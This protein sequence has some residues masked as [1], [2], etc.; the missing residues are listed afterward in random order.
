L[1]PD[2]DPLIHVQARLQLMTTLSALPRGDRITH[3]RLQELHGLSA[4]NL[5]THLRK[6]EEA[7]YVEVEKAFRGRRPVTWVS[8]TDKG[9]EA[10]AAYLDALQIYL[11]ASGTTTGDR[12]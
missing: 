1:L 4:G 8:V 5:T 2:L 11:N 12:T 9:R 7:G 3:P 10:F 6:L